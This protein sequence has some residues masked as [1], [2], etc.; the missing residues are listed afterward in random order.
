MTPTERIRVVAFWVLMVILAVILTKLNMTG[1]ETRWGRVL[2]FWPLALVVA[3]FIFVFSYD[4]AL[5]RRRQ[6]QGSK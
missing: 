6:S 5:K 3:L 1:L 4:R 2:N